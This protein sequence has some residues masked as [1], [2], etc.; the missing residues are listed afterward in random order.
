MCCDRMNGTRE[1]CSSSV[2]LVAALCQCYPV[3]EEC[4]YCAKIIFSDFP[5]LGT[6]VSKVFRL[7]LHSMENLYLKKVE[8]NVLESWMVIWR[9]SV[10]V[11]DSAS[12]ARGRIYHSSHDGGLPQEQMLLLCASS[13]LPLFISPQARENHLSSYLPLAWYRQLNFT[14]KAHHF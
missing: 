1:S 9:S 10:G 12:C 7:Q 4:N 11:S 3:R 14:N 13:Y 5:S 8:S 2:R 6:K